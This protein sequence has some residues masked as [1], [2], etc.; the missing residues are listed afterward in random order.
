MNEILPN[1]EKSEVILLKLLEGIPLNSRDALSLGLPLTQTR[2]RL[3]F[4]KEIKRLNEKTGF[5]VALF[6][7]YKAAWHGPEII[8]LTFSEYFWYDHQDNAQLF[9]I[10]SRISEWYETHGIVLDDS[11]LLE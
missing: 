3:S 10:F 4:L 7:N 8:M 1:K 6:G 5:I 11:T 9:K 2:H